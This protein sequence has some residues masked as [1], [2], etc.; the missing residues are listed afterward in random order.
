[1][2]PHTK[3]TIGTVLLALAFFASLAFGAVTRGMVAL[4]PTFTAICSAVE[5]VS[6]RTDYVR[7]Y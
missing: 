1:M 5:F 2:R 7:S 3:K 4:I 6:L